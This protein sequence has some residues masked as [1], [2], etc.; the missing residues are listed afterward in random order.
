MISIL[1]YESFL[2]GFLI[3]SSFILHTG[4]G[5]ILCKFLFLISKY[6]LYPCL[7]SKKVEKDDQE[8]LELSQKS[9]PS[10]QNIFNSTFQCYQLERF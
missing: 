10:S 6:F 5:F 3:Y 2:S 8:N 9:K 1:N 7:N 4:I